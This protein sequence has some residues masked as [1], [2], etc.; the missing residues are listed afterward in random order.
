MLAQNLWDFAS[1]SGEP[2]VNK[3]L[4]QPI[5]NYNMEKGWYV[6]ATTTIT[7]DWEADSGE[8]WTVP[9]GGGVGRIIRV[10][11]LPLDL[12]LMSYWNVGKARI[13]PGLERAVH[14]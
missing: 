7:A 3:G 8:E 4:F 13:R 12:K 10:G 5:I 1:E 11:K 2:D 9:L 6:S 14:H